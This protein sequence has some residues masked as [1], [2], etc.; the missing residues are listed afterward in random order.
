MEKIEKENNKNDSFSDNEEDDIDVSFFNLSY[1][2][3]DENQNKN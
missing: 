3:N 2:E 1:Y